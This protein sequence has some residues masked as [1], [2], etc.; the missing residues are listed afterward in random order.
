MLPSLP[1]VLRV[2]LEAETE[3]LKRCRKL[4]AWRS[5][6]AATVCPVGAVP[7]AVRL[8][9]HRIDIPA[10]LVKTGRH[11]RDYGWRWKT[12][13]RLQPKQDRRRECD[14]VVPVV[15]VH[16]RKQP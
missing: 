3:F 2:E 14:V 1:P 16:D 11:R 13:G 5:G 4:F 9:E 6:V 12:V 7:I 8:R 15:L 10:R